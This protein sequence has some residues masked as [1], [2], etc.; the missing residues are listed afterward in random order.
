MPMLMLFLH[1]RDGGRRRVPN[2]VAGAD[3]VDGVD[4]ADGV[5]VT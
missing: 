1:Q 4:G 2:R 3:G 5:G